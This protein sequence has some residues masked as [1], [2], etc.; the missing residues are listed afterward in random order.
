MTAALEQTSWRDVDTLR[1]EVH[2]LVGQYAGR[3]GRTPAQVH[4][5]LRIAVPGPPSAR[6]T[7]ETL[8]ARRDWLLGKVG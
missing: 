6:A 5:D 7:W 3:T 4:V 2:S 8:V 1:K